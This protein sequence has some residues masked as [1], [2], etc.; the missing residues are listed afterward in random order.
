MSTHKMCG[1]LICENCGK[2][3]WCICRGD[4]ACKKPAPKVKFEEGRQFWRDA[5][6]RSN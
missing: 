4:N 3:T 5:I 2:C 6:V 1:Q